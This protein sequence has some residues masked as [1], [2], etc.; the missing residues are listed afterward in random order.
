MASNCFCRGAFPGAVRHFDFVL[1]TSSARTLLPAR[2][3]N[4]TACLVASL[5]P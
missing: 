4:F 5:M 2:K 1:F 3:A